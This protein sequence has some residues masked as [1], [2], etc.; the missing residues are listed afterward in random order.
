[1]ILDINN[2][3]KI[4]NVIIIKQKN[5]SRYLSKIGKHSKSC[6]RKFL[7]EGLIPFIACVFNASHKNIQTTDVNEGEVLFI[8]KL[9]N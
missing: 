8:D 9:D 5:Y 3:I 7:F 6:S 1:M 2:I 4:Q